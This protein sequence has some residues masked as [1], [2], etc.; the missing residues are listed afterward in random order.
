[1]SDYEDEAI[2][3]EGVSV[4]ANASSKTPG[5]SKSKKRKI[6]RTKSEELHADTKLNGTSS[7]KAHIKSCPKCP[8]SSTDPTQTELIAPSSEGESLSFGK[9]DATAIRKSVA[10]MII[11]DELPFRFV[12]AKRFRKCMFTACPRFRM[13]SRW[14]VARD[15]YKI[16]LDEKKNVSN[17]LKSS[18]ARV[19]LTTDSWTSLQRVNYMCLTLHYID[20]EWK[21]HKRI[22]NFCPISSHKGEDIG[23]A[24]EKCLRDWGLDNVF[25]ITVDNASSND[26][27]TGYLRKKFNNLG[28]SILDGKFLHMRCIAHIVNLVV[29]DALKENN[30]SICRVRGAVRYVRQSPSRLQK[31]KECIQMEKIQSKALL[32]LDVCTRW[33]S[34]YLMLDS[35]QKFERAFERFEELDPHYGHDLLNSEGIPDHDD[36]ENVRRLC[37]FLGHFYDPTV[38]VSGSLYVTS[39]TYFPEICE[40]YSILRDWIKSRDSHFSSM[41]QRMKDKFDKYWG[42]VDKMNMLLYVATVLDPRR[43]YVYVDFCFKRMYSNDEVS[44]LSK[45]LRQVMMDLFNE[46]KR[47]HESSSSSVVETF[48]SNEIVSEDMPSIPQPPKKGKQKAVNK[49]FMKYLEEIGCANQITELDKYITEQLENG[50]EDDE[51]DILNWWKTNAHRLPILSSLAR[52]VLAIPISTVASESVFSTGGRV[53]DSYRSSLTPRVVQALICAQD[54]LRNETEDSI[55]GE[56]EYE[57]GEIDKVDLGLN[58]EGIEDFRDLKLAFLWT[59]FQSSKVQRIWQ[60]VHQSFINYF[61]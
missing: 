13:P 44:I 55:D 57:T 10:E 19:S 27:A 18:C 45:K 47:L 53:L 32:S 56:I 26:V 29:N 39:N 49:E 33:N 30:E 3:N 40:V 25:T 59:V 15:C 36:W 20:N 17:I 7:L 6:S 21:V 8:Y 46:Y 37:M 52:D 5:A 61:M 24:I 38:K 1:M 43:K 54:W 23:K 22:L 12:E 42:N 58:F 51:F 60:N 48:Q 41:A 31:F 28:S 14:T 50:G 9:F 2:Q 16:Y 4:D 11:I 35:A 34:T